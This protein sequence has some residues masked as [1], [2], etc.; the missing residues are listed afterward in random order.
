MRNRTDAGA[1]L[2]IALLLLLLPLLGI[3]VLSYQLSQG[4][5]TAQRA[6]STGRYLE[7]S[8]SYARA[9]GFQPWRADLWETAGRY[10]LQAGDYQ[11]AVLY[12]EKA[13]QVSIAI[14]KGDTAQ[15]GLTPQG[16]LDL[17]DAYQS[18]GDMQKALSAWYAALKMTGPTV[19]VLPRLFR[20][21]RAMGD[22]ASATAD[23][24]VLVSLQPDYAPYYYEMGLLLAVQQPEAALDYLG[25]AA[26]LDSSLAPAALKLQG[27]LRSARA[28]ENAY[29]LLIAG[30]C[31]ASQDE[32]GLAAISFQQAVYERPDYAE[33]WAYLGEARQ[34]NSDSAS[35]SG[36]SAATGL[37]ELQKALELDPQSLSA[38]TFLALYWMR[39][40][41][42]DLAEELIRAAIELDPQ[43]PVLVI[44]LGEILAASG[45]L[46]SAFQVFSQAAAIAPGD[47][48]VL[49]SLASYSLKYSYQV[50]EVALPAARQAIILAPKDVQ[51]LDLMA[52]VL[53]QLGDLASA[54]R[55]LV[56]A[57][58]VDGTYAPSHLHLGLLFILSGEMPAARQEL[59]QTLA[60]APQGSV[61]DQ[62]RRLL[63]TYFP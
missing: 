56:Q 24:R 7:A 28:E 41:K 27:C 25:Q 22:Y 18:L 59:D 36:Y 31:L 61:A 35:A 49:R 14:T 30:R 17:G 55:F 40:E 19:E 8:Q 57:L 12:L 1:Q 37:V 54:E 29:R 48:A 58:T 4:L 5:Q 39:Q 13:S 51:N 3:A 33:A 52:Q 10:A 32:W 21:H 15:A 16:W 11:T 47:P 46:Q 42:Y 38:Q 44:Q 53:I 2:R 45:D 6:V 63:E 62:A 9:A 26:E 20:A 43:N 60:L 50:A 34:H 23:L